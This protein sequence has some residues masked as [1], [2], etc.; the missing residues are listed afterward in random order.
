MALPHSDKIIEDKR[1]QS[2]I[3]AHIQGNMPTKPAK[4]PTAPARQGTDRNANSGLST[5]SSGSDGGRGGK[6]GGDGTP[7][8]S[9]KPKDAKGE[10]K[11]KGGDKSP[12]G[13][14]G[15]VSPRGGSGSGKNTPEL[16]KQI[17]V[18][19]FW[20]KCNYGDK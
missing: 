4:Q 3:D 1:R 9:P 18:T 14:G 10:G 15:K 11:G 20:G 2:N 5:G 7:P 16:G 17:C 12:R 19:H 8:R 6:G 13:K